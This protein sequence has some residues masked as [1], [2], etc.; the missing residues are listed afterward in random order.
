M[1]AEQKKRTL[2]LAIGSLV[3]GIFFLIPLL[4]AVLS[5]VAI[6]LGIIALNT[7]SKNQDTLK[8]K[9][10]A[11]TGI[12]LGAIGMVIIPIVAMLAAIAIPNFLRARILANDRVAEAS[13]RGIAAAAEDYAASHGGAYP[14]DVYDLSDT[15]TSAISQS[16][17]GEAVNG[18]TYSFEFGR[19]GYVVVAEPEICFVTGTKVITATTRGIIE[20]EDCQ[21]PGGE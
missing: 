21:R 10:L 8:G 12:V 9:G 3:C 1:T 5:L 17:D 4:G 7:I 18:Y 13:I 11:I 20:K 15:Q 14:M 19:R 2:G 6:I 16:L